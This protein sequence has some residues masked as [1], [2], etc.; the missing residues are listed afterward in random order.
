MTANDLSGPNW[1]R[2][3]PFPHEVAMARFRRMKTLQTFAAVHASV[4]N[5]I[6]QDRHLVSRP[7]YKQRRSNALTDWRCVMA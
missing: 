4:H 6:A 1:G 3:K 5:H 2:A 7:I